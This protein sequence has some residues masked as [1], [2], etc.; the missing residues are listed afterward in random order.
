MD[1]ENNESEIFRSSSSNDDEPTL[2]LDLNALQQLASSRLNRHCVHT[3]RLTKGLYNEI[4]L[5]QFEAGPDCIARLSCDLNHPAAKFASEVATMKYIAQNTSIKVPEVYDWDGTPNCRHVALE[6][7]GCLYMDS[8][9]STFRIGPIVD[10]VFYV[11]GRNAIPSSTGPFRSM[12]E[13]FDALIQKEKNFFEIHGVQ[14]LM[15]KQKMDQITAA[16]QVANLIE[17]MITL[18]AKLFKP[19]D[20]SIDQ[21][22]FFLVHGDFDAQNILVER[23]V[24]DEIKIVGII[25]WE[26]SRTGT[27]WNLC[28]YPIWIQE[29]EEPFR[30]L[31]DLEVQ[32][33]YEKQKLR[34]FFHGEMVAKLGSRSGQILEMK[35]RDS[36]IKKLEDMFTYMV[37][38]FAGLQGLLESFFYRYGSELA[39]VHFDDPIVEY[40]WE[41]IIKVQI[42]P[43]RAITYLLSKDELLLNRIMEEVPFHYIASVYYELKSNGYNFSW[44]Q[45][46]TIAFYM[47]KNEGKNDP[48]FMNVAV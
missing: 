14:E 30:N 8:M 29:V 12:Q 9:T 2:D 23:S 1:N 3:R 21:K 31:T 10:P 28:Q 15:K 16:S 33:C 36:R 7:I 42:P 38:S 35:K 22:P 18:Q 19:F 27:L 37:H 47:W 6:E 34:E 11:E 4:Y 25:D 48:Q 46:S 5:L 44:Q 17:Q 45:A 39:N 24:N 26:F 32:E 13:L 41:D 20:K 40:F 43:K